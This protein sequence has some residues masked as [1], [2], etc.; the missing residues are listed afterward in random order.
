MDTSQ[1]N[2]TTPYMVMDCNSITTCRSQALL[3]SLQRFTL[4]PPCFAAHR[5]VYA[6]KPKDFGETGSMSH[7]H[8]KSTE[9][10]AQVPTL[11]QL[12]LDFSAF[13]DLAWKH[14]LPSC[15]SCCMAPCSPDFVKGSAHWCRVGTQSTLALSLEGVLSVPHN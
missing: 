1:R 6:E 7:R 9:A 13:A 5:R 10:T 8:C 15:S 3:P 12:S 14:T 11:T 4:A 2:R